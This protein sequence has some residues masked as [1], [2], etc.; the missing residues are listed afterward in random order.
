LN[1]RAA[2]AVAAVFCDFFRK[3]LHFFLKI[4]EKRGIFAYNLVM[5]EIL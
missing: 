2:Y 1:R 5:C 4:L 3:S